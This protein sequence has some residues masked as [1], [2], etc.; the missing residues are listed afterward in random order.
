MNTY[1]YPSC[2]ESAPWQVE[3]VPLWTRTLVGIQDL[4]D[5]VCPS[6]TLDG[7]GFHERLVLVQIG[8]MLGRG[9]LGKALEELEQFAI[10]HLDAHAQ[11]RRIGGA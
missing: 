7:P 10:K 11:W 9:A 8:W 5:R 2:P 6:C 1:T 3:V 4:R